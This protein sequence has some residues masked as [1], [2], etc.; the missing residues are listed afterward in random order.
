MYEYCN[1]RNSSRR[2]D[3]NPSIKPSRN[4]SAR[5]WSD[6]VCLRKRHPQVQPESH[7]AARADSGALSSGGEIGI[8]AAAAAAAAAA[9]PATPVAAGTGDA[10]VSETSFVT[11][12]AAASAAAA[13]AA[14]TSAQPP[15]VT[16]LSAPIR[17]SGSGGSGGGGGGGGGGAKENQERRAKLLADLGDGTVLVSWANTDVEEVRSPVIPPSRPGRCQP[18][19]VLFEWGRVGCWTGLGLVL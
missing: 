5:F 10:S 11:A 9:T 6:P 3:I 12:G 18:K 15:S 19:S 13:A 1:T 16:A 17:R 4:V 14:G 7:P 8:A 2:S